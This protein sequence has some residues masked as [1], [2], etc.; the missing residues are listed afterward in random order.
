MRWHVLIAAAT[1]AACTPDQP[2]SP[3]E[4][5]PDLR[6]QDASAR[7]LVPTPQDPARPTTPA[8]GS[9]E[10]AVAI[11]SPTPASGHDDPHS[12][13]A[14]RRARDGLPGPRSGSPGGCENGTR[15]P[16]DTWKVDCNECACGDGGQVTCT[17]MACGYR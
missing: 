7:P 5:W 1:L 8:L 16:G 13:L 3:P 9:P 14:P 17:A 10:A 2:T 6:Q 12:V 11:E 15:S 4:K